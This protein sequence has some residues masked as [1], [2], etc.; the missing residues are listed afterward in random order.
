MERDYGNMQIV[1][2]TLEITNTRLCATVFVGQRR[3]I[4]I[5]D[6]MEIIVWDW[7]TS[8]KYLVSYL[9]SYLR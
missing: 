7:T 6:T 5:A 2:V 3:P 8:K 9:V 4:Y 1:E